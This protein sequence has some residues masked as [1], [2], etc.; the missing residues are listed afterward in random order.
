MTKRTV[1]TLGK[2][3]K[4][5]LIFAL[6]MAV[7]TVNVSAAVTDTYVYDKDGKTQ[8]APSPAQATYAIKGEDLGI[9][10]FNKPQDLCFSDSGAMYIADTE[11]NRIV[12]IDNVG[13]TEQSVKIIDRF[14]SDGK[15]DGFNT[16]S[17]IFVDSQGNLFVSDT[18]N[19]RVVKLSPQGE[20]LQIVCAPN[21]E[22]LQEDFVFK[23]TKL[24]VDAYN[25]MYIIS[26]GY[27]AGLM[28]FDPSGTYTQSMGAPQVVKSLIDQFWQS[29]QTKAQR[30]RTK[31][32]VPTEYSNVSIDSEGFLFVTT[33]AYDDSSG[34]EPTPLRK[35]NAKGLDVLNRVENPIG[36][37]IKSGETYKGNSTFSDVCMLDYGDFAVLDQNRGRVFVYNSVGEL[38]YQFGGPGSVSGAIQL[39][40]AIGYYDS[41][42][43]VLDASKM[44]VTVFELTEYGK[45]L[46][47][48]AKARQEI[49][50]E[51]EEALWEQ[52]LSRNVNCSMAM[53][54]LGNAAYKAKNMELA[55]EY[56]K[57]AGDREGY[58]KAYA[59]VR[60]SWIEDNVWVICLVIAGIVAVSIMLSRN[61][62]RIDKFISQRP[63]IKAL[64]YAGHCAT[65][66]MDG[67]WCLKREKCGNVLSA[68]VLI[69]L[70]MLVNVVTSL[71]TGFIFNQ[72]DLE[73]YS[74][75]SVLYIVAAVA[76]WTICQWCVTTLMNGEGRFK[77]IYISTCYATLPYTIINVFALLLSQ[78][79]LKNEGDFY[80]VLVSLAMIWMVFLLVCSVKQTHDF[81]IGKTLVAIL[82]ILIVILLIIFISMLILALSQQLFD[83][84]GDLISEAVLAV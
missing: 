73:K 49:D 77:D 62:N 30:E 15:T 2:L 59:F 1:L 11:N 26:S 65:H 39:G 22:I 78:V 74:I 51:T 53:R 80:Y 75:F 36:D 18:N 54:G 17:G 70:C 55:M 20:L 50:F 7:L 58:S 14:I 68:T 10:S 23:P 8:P 47:G 63:N 84:I 3:S 52:I 46:S 45:L 33:S 35:L 38:L 72:T 81:S 37:A 25:Q 24:V 57:L 12:V 71:G 60:R 31:N 66:P 9:G 32:Y 5:I 34:S 29:F 42:Y 61:K 41:H 13:Q 56:Y 69:L 40:V 76:L 27:N 64:L 48:V 19:A 28:E 44:Q 83:F 43:Y 4:L 79:L 82:I 21:D 67:F 16:P 6:L